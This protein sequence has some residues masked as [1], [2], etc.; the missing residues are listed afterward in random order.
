[1]QTYLCEKTYQK[2]K[3]ICIKSKHMIKLF[4]IDQQN[5]SVD[6]SSS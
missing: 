6:R 1:M 4:N 2:T 3:K 5:K